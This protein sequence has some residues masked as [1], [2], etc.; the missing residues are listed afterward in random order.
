V[1][2]TTAAGPATSVQQLQIPI[3]VSSPATYTVRVQLTSLLANG[4]PNVAAPLATADFS[5]P[6][7]SATDGWQTFDLS[8]AGFSLDA[9]TAYA[10]VVS[11]PT[12]PNWDWASC[13]DMALPTG[14]GFSNTAFLER[15]SGSSS[16]WQNPPPNNVYNG[17]FMTT[18]ASGTLAPPPPFVAPSCASGFVACGTECKRCCSDSDCPSSF[19]CLPGGSDCENRSGCDLFACGQQGRTCTSSGSNCASCII[20]L[21]PCPPGL[22]CFLGWC[23]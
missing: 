8:G 5:R 4:N 11:N 20:F 14:A 7:T 6:L 12:G 3:S 17:F 10:V 2:F 13:A 15:P 1:V 23:T 19:T 18:A 16:N 21:R 22:S 9:S